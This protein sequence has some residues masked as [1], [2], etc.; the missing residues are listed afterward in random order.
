MAA[1]ATVL[2]VGGGHAE[3]PL[4]RA[5]HAIGYRVIT[6][7]NRPDDLGHAHADLY[8]PAD[9]SKPEEILDVAVTHDVSAI[10]SGCNDFAMLSTAF[11]CEKLGLPGHDSYETTVR[12]HHKDRFRELLEELQLDT[13]RSGVVHDATQA[14]AL[15]ER[16]GYPVI[17]KPVDLTGGKGISVCDS[18]EQ[19]SKAVDDALVLSRQDYVVVEQFL[20]GTRH[21][22]TCFVN[23][24][25]VGFWFADDEQYFLNPFLVSG[26]TTPTSMPQWAL[27]ELVGAVD[28]IASR[29]ELV[30]GLVHV[31]CIMT[32]AGPRII[33]VCRRC[34]GDLYPVFVELSTDYGYADAVVRSECGLAAGASPVGDRRGCITRHCIMPAREG[35]LRSVEFDQEVTARIVDE[36]VWWSPGQTVDNHLTQKFGIIFL[37]FENS[38]EMHD[39]T[40]QLGSRVSV[41]MT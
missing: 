1:N 8:V 16:I 31:Q 32:E 6:T 7:G 36:M 15:C 4:I 28:T 26:T 11:V 20:T 33:E 37:S 40:G 5:A 30:D 25:C 12:I 14:V 17:V 23:D 27:D 13:P 9:F 21:G 2:V 35:V 39:L 34:P 24:Q 41:D 18:P 38:D 3:I 22:F 19:L 10:V 29:L